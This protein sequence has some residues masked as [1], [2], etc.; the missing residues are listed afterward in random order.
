M[1]VKRVII[2][3]ILKWKTKIPSVVNKALSCLITD[4]N[5]ISNKL[6]IGKT[7]INNEY[8]LLCISIGI[9]WKKITWGWVINKKIGKMKKI[10]KLISYSQIG[11]LLINSWR[12]K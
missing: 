12:L 9:K 8:R 6:N 11:I 2:E 5:A 1:F 3:T 7:I 4:N 10:I